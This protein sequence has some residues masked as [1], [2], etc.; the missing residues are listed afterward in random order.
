MSEIFGEKLDKSKYQILPESRPLGGR[1]GIM[2]SWKRSQKANSKVLNQAFYL[3]ADD[4]NRI[5]EEFGYDVGTNDKYPIP[6]T[7]QTLNNVK[8]IKEA[9]Q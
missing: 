8:F 2:I 3:V 4:K 1:S 7:L 5:I 9:K 6:E